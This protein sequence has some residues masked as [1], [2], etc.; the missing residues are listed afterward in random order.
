MRWRA[1]SLGALLCAFA[2]LAC[3][4]RSGDP[5]VR[6]DSAADGGARDG[7]GG[8][9]DPPAMGGDQGGLAGSTPE[10]P[11]APITGLC[12]PCESSDECGDP[13]DACLWQDGES[14]CGR[15]CRDGCPEGYSCTE[16]A[17]S[18]LEQCVPNDGCRE[19]PSSPPALA[20]IREYLLARIN[21]ERLDHGWPPFE[22]M[23][24]LDELAQDSALAYA[25]TDEPYGKFVNECGDPIWPNCTCG[26][27]AERE[28]A[29]ARIGLDWLDAIEGALGSSPDG[30]RF[31]ESFL[32]LDL[33]HVGIGFYISGDEAW[34][35]LSFG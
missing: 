2:V 23:P 33:T 10:T 13:N 18:P 22:P 31:L 24:C 35:A 9:G 29:V 15:D 12:G 21:A 28:V 8:G 30:E 1:V 6:L 14:F 25:R 5:V 27:R 19:A 17:N 7:E 26:W 4:E 32:G 16:L 34:L 20:E 3:G 11:P